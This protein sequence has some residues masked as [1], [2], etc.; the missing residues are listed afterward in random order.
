MH[1]SLSKVLNA[2]ME[3]GLTSFF[4]RKAKD[5]GVH[6]HHSKPVESDGNM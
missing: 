4:W 1:P 2:A 3:G 6:L 5:E